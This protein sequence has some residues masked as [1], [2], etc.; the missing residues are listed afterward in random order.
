MKKIAKFF[1]K[2]FVGIYKFFDKILITPI[3]RLVYLSGSKFKERTLT[4]EKIL[5]RNNT[6]IYISLICAFI[7]FITIDKKIITLVENESTVLTNQIVEVEYNDEAYVIE[8]LPETTDI[9]LMGRR[10]DLYLAEQ[11]GDHKVSLDLSNYGVGTHK[12]ALKYNNPINTLD[13]KIDPS[14][15]TIIIYPKVS[16]VKTLSIDII[17]TDK[18]KETLIVSSVTLDKDEVIVKSYKEKLETVASVKAIVDAYATNATVAGTYT[19]E[20]VKLVAYDDKG[21]EISGVEIIP[22]SVTATVTIASPSK[23]V[24][25]KI[26]P[27]GEVKSGSAINTITQSVKN[28]TIYGDEE[29]LKNT[30]SIPVEVDVTDI[31]ED[32][33]IQLDIVKPTGIRYMSESSVTITISMQKETSIEVKDVGIQILNKPEG[34]TAQAASINDSK[35]TV[36]V[37]GVQKLLD[38]LDTSKIIATIDLSEIKS[39]GIWDVPVMVTGENLLLTYTPKV[40]S[41]KINITKE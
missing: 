37:K 5:N 26:V 41:I 22:V 33:K 16:E 21:T 40:K 12:V 30:T 23:E 28:I 15:A 20:N 14:V 38:E 19:L 31:S 8:G 9:I 36:E 35:I 34:F 10:S 13:Y 3:S 7:C 25:L 27:V 4:F 2:I 1:K 39:E 29:V 11:L 24:P 18:L 6:L 32:K 17:N